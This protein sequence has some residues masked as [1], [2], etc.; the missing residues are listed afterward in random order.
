MADER[1]GVA[2]PGEQHL[3]TSV[4]A[5]GVFVRVALDD[6]GLRGADDDR[7]LN[8]VS[9][10]LNGFDSPLDGVAVVVSAK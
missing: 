6:D 7:E 8:D 3:V 10:L 2:L 5:S 9:D 4:E 1:G